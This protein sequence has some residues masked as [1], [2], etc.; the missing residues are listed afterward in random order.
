MLIQ[1]YYT[2]PEAYLEKAHFHNISTLDT[3]WYQSAQIFDCTW[4]KISA[5]MIKI[6]V[7]VILHTCF[8]GNHPWQQCL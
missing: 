4:Y 5:L 2:G 1:N 6:Y 7:F 3:T 8:Y